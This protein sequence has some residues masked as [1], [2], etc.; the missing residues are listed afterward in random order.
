MNQ[1]E[2]S[3]ST[4]SNAK[5]VYILY[6]VS[7]VVG[8]TGLI[9]VIMAYVYRQ[10]A[11]D[12]LRSHY[13]F[14]IRTFWIGLL[15]VLVGMLLSTVFIGFL[16][17]LFWVVWLIIRCVKGLQQLERGAPVSDVETWLW[18]K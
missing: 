4:A 9:G 13:R 16:I 5:V 12:W 11:A 14:Q 18:P 10:D 8:L 1:I 6:L 3:T 15:Y 17:L 7:I 2:P